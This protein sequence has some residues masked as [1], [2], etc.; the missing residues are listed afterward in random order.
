MNNLK[1]SKC[2]IV[3]GRELLKDLKIDFK[4]SCVERI[5]PSKDLVN[6]IQNK[7]DMGVSK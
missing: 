2:V 5:K 7:K 4:D 6:L 3:H 1:L